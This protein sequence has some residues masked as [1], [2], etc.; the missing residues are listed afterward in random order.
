MKFIINTTNIKVGGALQVSYS[1]LHQ[2]RLFKQHEYYVFVSPQL[3]EV[4]DKSTFPSNF[5]FYH[6]HNNPTSSIKDLFTFHRKLETLESKINPDFVF[7]IF[8]PSLW[9]SRAPHLLGFANGVYLFDKSRFI[10]KQLLFNV[11]KRAYYYIRRHFLLRAIKREGTVFWV[12]TELARKELSKSIHVD[13]SKIYVI[14]NT[15]DT[16][17]EKQ[18]NAY[19]NGHA[20]T[21]PF[22]FLY[23]AANY[24]HKNLS[25][26][27]K[28]IPLLKEK[29]ID[30]QFYVTLPDDV[31]QELFPKYSEDVMLQ[32]LGPLK[33]QECPAAY[34]KTDALFFPSLLE[35]F[36][37]NYPEAMVMKKPII[38]SNLPF[39]KRI[40]SDAA[41][42]FNPYSPNDIVEKIETFIFDK[43][44]Q[45][46]LI[47]NGIKRL[48]HFDT[49]FT[50]AEKLLN[51]MQDH[52]HKQ[53]CAE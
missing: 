2:L 34:I 52:I 50:R 51:I 5:H 47:E 19:I 36:S 12:E 44:L 22:R 27:N 29:N 33:P 17:Y 46:Q 30:C 21:H 35:T 48:E 7:T 4:I 1:L 9:K 8:G 15:Y 14:T 39:A 42:Y 3:N 26:F 45:K 24:K 32:N 16:H 23:L 18:Q 49:A 40:C 41:F 53:I 28:I 20:K 43:A 11:F 10:Q 6:F 38:T 25:I 31:F 37:S 13:I